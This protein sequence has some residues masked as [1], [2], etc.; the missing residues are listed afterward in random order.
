MARNDDAEPGDAEPRDAPSR[1]LATGD[2]ELLDIGPERGPGGAARAL[3]P[4]AR[5]GLLLLTLLA[6]AGLVASTIARGGAQPASPV[7]SPTALASG[8]AGSPGVTAGATPGPGQVSSPVPVVVTTAGHHLLGVTQGW[9]LIARGPGVLVR[10]QMAAGRVTRTIVPPLLSSGWVSFV[11]GRNQA[12]IRPIDFVPGYA[13]PDGAP[14]RELPRPLQ[15]G[16]PAF[17][18][19][20]PDHL[21]V[22]AADAPVMMLTTF[23]GTPTGPTIA[24]PADMSPL[25][26]TSDGAGYLLLTGIGGVYD[27]TPRGLKRVTTGT[28]VA[29]GPTRWLVIECDD[30]HRCA[31]VV[32][33]RADWSRHVLVDPSGHPL[34]IGDDPAGLV[35]VIS[36]DG[37]T[38]AVFNQGPDGTTLFLLSLATG[39]RRSVG[40]QLD[41][42]DQNAVWSPDGR[43]LFAAV[44]NGR[45]AVIDPHTGQYSDLEMPLP[46]LS[47]LA[48][49]PAP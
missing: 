28:L 47:Q 12:V 25:G 38:A 23:D 41:Q 33:N 9:E 49:R 5:G 34:N 20:D 13:V 39:S 27:A 14:A 24:I 35:G 19:P 7:A 22:Q 11:A 44:A 6:V 17:P 21:W 10:I 2:A 43:W 26:A 18:G 30:A 45:L 42:S 36:P 37:S 29:V 32:V 16:G 1:D 15:H 46:S 4:R 3:P 40:V 31:T 8:P 48:V